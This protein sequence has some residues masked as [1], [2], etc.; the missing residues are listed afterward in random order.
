MLVTTSRLFDFIDRPSFTIERYEIASV[1]FGDLRRSLR[2]MIVSLYESGDW[3]GREIADRLRTVLSEWLTVPVRFDDAILTALVQMGGPTAVEFR[4]G[5]DIRAH[6]E[7]A[8]RFA[9]NIMCTENPV[10]AMLAKSIRG[11]LENQ[12][13][14]R[15]MCHRRSRVHIE[16]LSDSSGV[17]AL[18]E[19]VFVHSVVDYRETE[20]FLALL[21][22][23]PLRSRGW[24][25]TPDAVIT[26]PRFE[27]L[28]QIIWSGCGDEP[29]FGYDPVSSH[30][31][32]CSRV[33]GKS[34][35]AD[36]HNPILQL[37]WEVRETRSRDNTVGQ[38]SELP[39]VNDLEV[40]NGLTQT[41]ELQRATMLQVDDAH[42][43]LYPHLS[44][45]LSIDGDTHIIDYRLPLETLHEGMFL[46]LPVVADGSLAGLQ[47]EEGQFSRKWKTSLQTE[48]RQDPEGF[49][50]RLRDAGLRLRGLQSR[51]E[52]WCIP[53]TTVIPAPQHMSHF[54]IL[55]SVLGVDFDSGSIAN[56]CLT[57]WWQYAW[58]EVRR[59][60]GQAIQMGIQEQQV[61]D[62]K[63]L[64]VVKSLDAM[65]RVNLNNSV[66]KLQIPMNQSNEIEGILHF[67]RIIAIEEGLRVPPG[68]LKMLCEL[69]R[70][71]Q[72][73][74]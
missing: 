51:I 52:H 54:E 59:S 15:I 53:A 14:F 56:K 71:D 40:F 39:D 70:I 27:T 1:L 32:D 21:K 28:I 48:Y 41:T 49:A 46:I 62:E 43:I 16:S 17:I 58:D 10:R 29:G 60:R 8:S 6:Y 33:P 5:R 63:M 34:L 38:Y 19:N 47:A 61:W 9:R 42:G 45:V 4:W 26:S 72:W 11:Y 25:A 66:F 12:Q 37:N 13:S 57:S 31:S 73:R 74:V 30:L 3:E 65:I 55:I 7:D 23:G 44:R 50:N 20:P 36:H 67:Y 35:V 24:G 18:P 22:I 69:N 68:E 64:T 2:S